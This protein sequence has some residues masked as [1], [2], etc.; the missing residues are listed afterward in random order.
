MSQ[1]P[2]H[3]LTSEDVSVENPKSVSLT[4][5]R[6]SRRIEPTKPAFQIGNVSASKCGEIVPIQFSGPRNE[7]L[8][9]GR[10]E[11]LKKKTGL[12]AGRRY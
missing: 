1:N 7:F 2:K 6:S 5:I 4:A 8:E 11:G 3:L 10:G 9:H 12:F